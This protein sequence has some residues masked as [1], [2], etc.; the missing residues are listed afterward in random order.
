MHSKKYMQ[1]SY[2]I[3]SIQDIVCWLL[4]AKHNGRQAKTLLHASRQ[5]I[6]HHL[7][8]FYRADQGC[9]VFSTKIVAPGQ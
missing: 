1:N 3:L 5:E 8:N 6:L 4:A 7:C 2:L 9:K